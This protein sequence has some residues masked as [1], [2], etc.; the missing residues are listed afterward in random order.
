MFV[1]CELLNEILSESLV[2][3]GK[4]LNDLSDSGLLI[5]I[6]LTSTNLYGNSSKYVIR[7]TVFILTCCSSMTKILFWNAVPVKF[8][9]THF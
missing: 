5:I 8:L 9:S 2:D 4:F 7:L 3:T 6:L 1:C